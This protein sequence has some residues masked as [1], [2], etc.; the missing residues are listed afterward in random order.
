MACAYPADAPESVRCCHMYE[1][2]MRRSFRDTPEQGVR[3]WLA[4]YHC[5][6]EEWLYSDSPFEPALPLDALGHLGDLARDAHDFGATHLDE[7]RTRAV[8]VPLMDVVDDVRTYVLGQ[9]V[10]IEFVMCGMEQFE[11]ARD[12]FMCYPAIAQRAYEVYDCARKYKV[13]DICDGVRYDDT[14]WA[15]VHDDDVREWLEIV[16][17]LVRY[18]IRLPDTVHAALA[19]E[20][21]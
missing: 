16:G 4:E 17:E 8:T 3:I 10:S 7:G 15:W 14:E 12:L 19:M 5:G 1:P 6:R 2:V 18:V 9:P 20:G 11:K 21:R 13:G